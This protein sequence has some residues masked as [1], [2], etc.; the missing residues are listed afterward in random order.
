[1]HQKTIKGIKISVKAEYFPDFEIPTETVQGELVQWIS[2]ND[3]CGRT[4]QACES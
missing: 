4:S 3:A 1:M 2:K